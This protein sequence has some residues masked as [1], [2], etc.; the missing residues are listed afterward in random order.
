MLFKAEELPQPGGVGGNGY[1]RPASPIDTYV[2][3]LAIAA[4][5]M[6]FY[7]AKKYKTQKI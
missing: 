3:I 4:I 5:L 2:Y 1:G 7:F 6:I